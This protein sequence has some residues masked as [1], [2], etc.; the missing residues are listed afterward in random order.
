M[1]PPADAFKQLDLI[2]IRNSKPKGYSLRFDL[3]TEEEGR[4]DLSLEATVFDYG[5]AAQLRWELDDIHVL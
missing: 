2:K 5:F 4:S 1:V 3:W